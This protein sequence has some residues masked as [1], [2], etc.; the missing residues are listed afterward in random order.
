[1]LYQQHENRLIEEQDEH[2]E[3]INEIAVRLKNQGQEINQELK[4]Q[5]QIITGLDA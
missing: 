5:N 3:E 1:M 2:I 4:R